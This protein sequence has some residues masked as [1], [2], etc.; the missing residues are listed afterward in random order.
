MT[1]ERIDA[2]PAKQPALEDLLTRINNVW[3][4][5]AEL[6]APQPQNMLGQLIAQFRSMAPVW[7]PPTRPTPSELATIAT[8]VLVA[9]PEDEPDW[10]CDDDAEV[11]L[12]A[13]P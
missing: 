9:L 4:R 5:W 10:D 1:E 11:L 7:Q 12:E 8:R 3:V 13:Q 6:A 2:G